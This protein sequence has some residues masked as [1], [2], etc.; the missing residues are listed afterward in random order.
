MRRLHKTSGAFAWLILLLGCQDA[1]S[2]VIPSTP[3]GRF[4]SAWLLANNRGNV[5]ALV[6]FASEHEG[7]VKMAPSQ[8]DSALWEA[9]RFANSQGRLVPV[10]LLHTSDTSLAILLRSD[11]TGI[12]KAVFRP[13][14][15]P[16]TT[17]VSVEISHPRLTPN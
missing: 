13:V 6:H 9:L 5:H 2:S 12:F 3:L 15:Q 10:Q 7:T 11:S 17:Q 16:N 8:Q 1:G 14:P 4:A